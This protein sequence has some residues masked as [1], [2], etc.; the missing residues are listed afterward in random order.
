[1]LQL[2]EEEE[3]GEEADAGPVSEGEGAGGE[4]KD[5]QGRGG[6]PNEEEEGVQDLH[7]LELRV[8]VDVRAMAAAASRP[9]SKADTALLKWVRGRRASGVRCE[10]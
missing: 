5:G 4:G 1:V 3:G 7:D 10:V 2:D 8:A 9:L 6:R